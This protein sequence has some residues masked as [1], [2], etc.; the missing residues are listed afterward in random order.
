M[1]KILLSSL[2]GMLLAFTAKGQFTFGPELSLNVSNYSIEAPGLF[3]PTTAWFFGGR[4]GGIADCGITDNIYIQPGIYYS[5][6]GIKYS[7]S[8]PFVGSIDF[9]SHINTIQIPINVQYKFGDKGGNRIFVGLGPFI[10]INLGGSAKVSVASS[11]LGA[12]FDSSA[13]FTVGSDSSDFI[14]R[15]DYGIG[16]NAGYQMTN[17]LFFRA[18]YQRGLAN[19]EPVGDAANSLKSVNY[20]ISAGYLIDSKKGKKKK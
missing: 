10:G 4:I 13:K 7:Y 3:T 11:F 5:L 18:Y 17:G 19:L 8:F 1:K 6:N 20:G 14:K 16:I 12:S 9:S 15:F 2:L